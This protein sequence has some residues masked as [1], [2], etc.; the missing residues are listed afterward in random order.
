MGD[1]G[2]QTAQFELKSGG[3][4]DNG[5]AL[6]DGCD[7]TCHI[8][9]NWQCQTVGRTDIVAGMNDCYLYTRLFLS[10]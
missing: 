9:Q 1:S 7:N 3:Q 4:V 8:E 10:G 5:V 2:Q 6:L